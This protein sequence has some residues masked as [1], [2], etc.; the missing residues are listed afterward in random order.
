MAIVAAQ[1]VDAVPVSTISL[2]ERGVVPLHI[3]DVKF[4]VLV[5]PAKC[6]IVYA[7]VVR[8]C[9]IVDLAIGVGYPDVSDARDDPCDQ[10]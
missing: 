9:E 5:S 8:A 10:R 7:D 6:K 3:F 1:V 2:L 4:H